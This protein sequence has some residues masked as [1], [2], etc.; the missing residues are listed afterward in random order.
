MALV[1]MCSPDFEEQGPSDDAQQNDLLIFVCTLEMR[2]K[3]WKI[4][5]RIRNVLI[6]IRGRIRLANGVKHLFHILWTVLNLNCRVVFLES[7]TLMGKRSWDKFHCVEI[8][9]HFGSFG[10]NVLRKFLHRLA[11]ADRCAKQL[12]DGNALRFCVP[13]QHRD[14]CPRAC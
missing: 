8:N 5:G 10:G 4:N 11:C 12:F 1:I 7:Q 2:W 3:V 6:W 13:I 14:K 9:H